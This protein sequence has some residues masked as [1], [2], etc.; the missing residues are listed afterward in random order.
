[1]VSRRSFYTSTVFYAG[2]ILALSIGTASAQTLLRPAEPDLL[3]VQSQ[4]REVHVSTIMQQLRAAAADKKTLTQAD[5]D[6]QIIE[7]KGNRKAAMMSS[8]FRIDLNGNN[9]LEKEEIAAALSERFNPAFNNIALAD[10]DGDGKISLL[11]ASHYIDRQIADGVDVPAMK[12]PLERLLALDPNKDGKLTATKLET[13]ALASFAKVDKDG[14]GLIS[15][16]EKVAAGAAGKIVPGAAL[17]RHCPFPKIDK[18]QKLYVV[19]AHESGTLSNTSVVGQDEETETATIDIAEGDDPIYLAVSSYTPMIWRI[20]GKTERVAHFFG[21]ARNG[22]GVV[23]IARDKVTLFNNRSCIERGEKAS[24]AAYQASLTRFF[25][26]PPEGVVAR[27]TSYNL[28][29]PADFRERN[30][31]SAAAKASINR[32]VFTLEGLPQQT[33][34]KDLEPALSSLKRFSPGGIADIDPEKVVVAA[35]K[36]ERYRVLPQEA[37]LVQLL[38][39]GSLKSATA[40]MAG[41]GNYIVLKEFPRFPAGLNGAHLVSFEFSPEMKLPEGSPGHSSVIVKP[42]A[43]ATKP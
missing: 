13:L 25:D 15:D 34:G 18:D 39:D 35:G 22:V 4:Y 16:A 21:S 10:T 28:S 20:T 3:R 40:R 33:T 14:D 11:E 27:Y 37:G 8:F 32:P 2:T 42:K 31:N 19:T 26:H 17:G 12:S 24:P 6:R 41:Q 5:I 30:E 36:A 29:L 23:G 9:V 43:A 1:M 7:S 38:Q